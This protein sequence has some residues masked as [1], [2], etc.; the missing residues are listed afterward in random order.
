VFLIACLLGFIAALFSKVL[1]KLSTKPVFLE[2]NSHPND[3]EA[4]TEIQMGAMEVQL[5]LNSD[6][7]TGIVTP[8]I[9]IHEYRAMFERHDFDGSGTISSVDEIKHLTT[10]LVFALFM[11]QIIKSTIDAERD[12]LAE[13]AN[14][15]Q[16]GL[17]RREYL[18]WFRDNLQP[19]LTFMQLP[20]CSIKDAFTKLGFEN[21]LEETPDLLKT[22]KESGVDT[23]NDLA[24]LTVEEL[25]N[26]GMRHF[27]APLFHAAM[28]VFH[29]ALESG[30]A[31][32]IA[33]AKEKL[34]T[35]MSLLRARRSVSAEKKAAEEKS[36]EVTAAEACARTSEAELATFKDEAET[37]V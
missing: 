12:N 1:C 11:K 29:A 23:A 19:C 30:D 32:P 22:L 36:A 33:H 20:C 14:L 7:L 5:E 9:D 37:M 27:K 2:T 8:H 34:S 18:E 28:A 25:R 17:S 35:M 31:V 4:T 26:C 24:E 10:N 15:G 21:E 6:D 16:Y 3:D 13:A